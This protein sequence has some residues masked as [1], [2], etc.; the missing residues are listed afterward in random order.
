MNQFMK[1][2]IASAMVLFSEH[3]LAEY[4]CAGTF[5]KASGDYEKGAQVTVSDYYYK[6]GSLVYGVP[7]AG[8]IDAKSIKL[9]KDCVLEKLERRLD[10]ETAL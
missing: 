5:L 3:A 10:L 4:T 1:V 8:Y 6:K 9:N 7:R 2:G